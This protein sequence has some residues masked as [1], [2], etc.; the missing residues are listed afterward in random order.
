[1]E[2]RT[3]HYNLRIPPPTDAPRRP[4]SSPRSPHLSVVPLQLERA[5]NRSQGKLTVVRAKAIHVLRKD[6]PTNG[7]QFN[8]ELPKE[9]LE[10]NNSDPTRQWSW[11]SAIMDVGHTSLGKL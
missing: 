7:A 9:V 1:M 8:L 4:P 6:R 11:S 3:G 5:Q 10:S 2:D